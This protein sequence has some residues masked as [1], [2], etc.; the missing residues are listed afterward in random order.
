MSVSQRLVIVAAAMIVEGE[1]DPPQTFLIV[2]RTCP[3]LF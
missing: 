1:L 3:D 2:F